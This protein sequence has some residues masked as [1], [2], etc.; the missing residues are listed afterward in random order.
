[1]LLKLVLVDKNIIA[2]LEGINND[3]CDA[4]SNNAPSVGVGLN[5][6]KIFEI[7]ML[8]Q[9]SRCPLGRV[10]HRRQLDDRDRSV[11]HFDC[12]LRMV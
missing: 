11:P 2:E 3:S 1:M 8:K 10:E 5:T 4:I 9:L 12:I 7:H 6:H